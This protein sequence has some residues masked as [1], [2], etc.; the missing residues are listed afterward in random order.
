MPP[1]DIEKTTAQLKE[2]LTQLLKLARI[3]LKF[4]IRPGPARTASGVPNGGPDHA[5]ADSPELLVDFSGPDTDL[6][7]QRGGELLES[8]EELSVRLLRLPTEE[9]DRISFDSQDFKSLRIDELKLTAE[10]AAAKVVKGGA[11]F[12]LSPMHSRDRRVI[13]LALKDNAA[14]RTESEGGGPYRKVVIFPA[15]Q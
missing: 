9:R 13:H 10:T 12:A 15:K 2:F 4:A 6:L 14:V 3:D 7:L 8:L 5:E 1:L 11:P